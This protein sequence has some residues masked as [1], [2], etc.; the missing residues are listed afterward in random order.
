MDWELK[1]LVTC[2]ALVGGGRKVGGDENRDEG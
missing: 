2:L 1:R